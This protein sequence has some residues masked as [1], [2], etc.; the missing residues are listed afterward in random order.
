MPLSMKYRIYAT[1]NKEREPDESV[2]F[3]EKN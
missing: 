2:P 3:Y 1:M